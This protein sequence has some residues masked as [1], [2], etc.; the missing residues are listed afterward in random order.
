MLIDCD[1]T[2]SLIR[3]LKDVIIGAKGSPKCKQNHNDKDKNNLPQ[4]ESN[5][6]WMGKPAGTGFV[7]PRAWQ[8]LLAEPGSTAG[9]GVPESVAPRAPPLPCASL[10]PDL[11]SHNYTTVGEDSR[12]NNNA[13]G[14]THASQHIQSEI[15]HIHLYRTC[16]RSQPLQHSDEQ[17]SVAAPSPPI[18]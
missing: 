14:M 6:R 15:T 5:A 18:T 4:A 2:A 8:R 7:H 9:W 13:M 11:V 17:F 16:L 10:P 1:T 12:R 3:D